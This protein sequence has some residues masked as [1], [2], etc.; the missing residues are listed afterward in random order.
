M[1]GITDE[2]IETWDESLCVENGQI[3]EI[4]V[5]GPVVTQAYF[6]DGNNTGLS[7][8]TTPGWFATEWEIW[9]F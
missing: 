1:I 5:K 4:V 7:K 2:G 6:N 9:V 3:G 8:L